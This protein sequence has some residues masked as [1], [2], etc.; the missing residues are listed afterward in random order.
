MKT[1]RK[2]FIQKNL[3][4]CL[5]ISKEN[6]SIV[7][8][9]KP[10]KSDEYLINII[11]QKDYFKQKIINKIKIETDI[12]FILHIVHN[13]PI[14][15]PRLFCLTSLSHLGIEI[16]DGKDILED[17]IE[18]KWDSKLS[19]NKIILKIPNFIKN[20]LEKKY[21]KL[22]LGKYI[23][24]YEY[25]YNLLIKIPHHYFN[26]IEQIINIKNN[27][28]EKRFLMITNSFFLIF[29]YKSDYF[30]YNELKLIFWASIY[31]IYV[32]KKDEPKFEFEFSKNE[33]N[34]ISIY[35]NTKE[36]DN[37]LNILL[38]IFKGRGVDYNI[39]GIEESKKLPIIYREDKD[40]KDNNEKNEKIDEDNN[41]NN[42]NEI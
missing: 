8:Y 35:I 19:A 38:Y 34:R 11:F 33:N 24:E 40:D 30:N 28:I 29:S 32:I 42:E 22:F 1:L 15:Q 20:C 7:I 25:D 6:N 18:N 31:S 16:C 12:F 26:Q 36:G 21:N 14:N 13:F 27:K 2:E 4:S 41:I 37:I 3:E 5:K 39:Q 9:Y 10:I 17:V 23:L